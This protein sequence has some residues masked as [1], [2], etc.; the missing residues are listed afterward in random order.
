VLAGSK[1]P[2]DSFERKGQLLPVL[3]A[4]AVGVALLSLLSGFLLFRNKYLKQRVEKLVNSVRT[5]VH[6]CPIS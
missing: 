2:P 1:V 6:A 5:T 3:I 4:C